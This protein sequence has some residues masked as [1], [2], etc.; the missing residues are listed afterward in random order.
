MARTDFSKLTES[1]KKYM[2]KKY[3]PTHLDK[4]RKLTEKWGRVT[5]E[6]E[7]IIETNS[8]LWLVSDCPNE[9]VIY[10]GTT[11]EQVIDKAYEAEG[12]E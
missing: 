8:L 3:Y 12:M 6:A 10:E 2:Q 9:R 4:L 5:L 7:F 1:E 11:P